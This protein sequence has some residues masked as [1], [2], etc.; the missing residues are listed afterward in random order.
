MEI[1]LFP[2][3]F[4]GVSFKLYATILSLPIVGLTLGYVLAYVLKQNKQI[5]K[6][7]AIECGVQNVPVALTVVAMSFPIEVS[8]SM[9]DFNASAP[10]KSTANQ[11]G[12]VSIVMKYTCITIFRSYRND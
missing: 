2:N 9:S 6:T 7:I 3:M 1:V 5:R 4:E 11:P 10:K 12:D 8:M